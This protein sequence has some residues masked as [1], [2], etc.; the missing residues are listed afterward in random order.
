MSALRSLGSSFQL[1]CFALKQLQPLDDMAN[2]IN[3]PFFFKRVE[4]DRST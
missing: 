4:F 3:Q 1:A 2:L